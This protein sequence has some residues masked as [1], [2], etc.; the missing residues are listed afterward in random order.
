MRVKM[1]GQA[2]EKTCSSGQ[3]RWE[4]LGSGG[5]KIKEKKG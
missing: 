1:A 5:E 4:R 3:R 2:E